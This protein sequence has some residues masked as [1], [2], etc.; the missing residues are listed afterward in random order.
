MVCATLA[1]LCAQVL[2]L[3]LQPGRRQAA[4]RASM[5]RM[6]S[7]PQPLITVTKPIAEQVWVSTHPPSAGGSENGAKCI[8]KIV[9]KYMSPCRTRPPPGGIIDL[10]KKPCQ[11]PYLRKG[12]TV[13][14]FRGKFNVDLKKVNSLYMQKKSSWP[15]HR[16]RIRQG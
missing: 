13:Q 11:Q 10:E 12:V 9:Q 6:P 2:H 15:S 1:E 4:R 7:P 8:Y 14:P 3:L 5:G 16:R